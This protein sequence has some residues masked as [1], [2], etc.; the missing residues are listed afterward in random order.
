MELKLGETG[1]FDF[2]THNSTGE[3]ADASV[4]ACEVFEDANDTPIITPTPIKRTGKTGNYRVQIDATTANGFE[5]NKS[6]NVVAAA[7][8][9]KSGKG[10]IGTFKVR[11]NHVGELASQT[12]TE[13]ILTE[14]QSHPTLAEIEAT[15][16]LAKEATLSR[17]L[18]L[19][20]D[21][22]V[23]DTIVRDGNGNKTSSILYA[24][25]SAANAITHDGVTGLT[26]KYNVAAT[27][28]G[29]DMTLFKVT[30]AT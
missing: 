17:I 26:G 2:P 25:N 13:T 8:T 24:Y 11:G 3:V 16:V 19:A 27:Y 10:V 7:T 5:V 1:Y 6:Y 29:N 14:S 18:G 12:T 20:L 28:S 22:H 4:V 21:N 15:T 23:E 9:D 30:R